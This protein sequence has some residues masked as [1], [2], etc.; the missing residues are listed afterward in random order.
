M[1]KKFGVVEVGGVRI[2]NTTREDLSMSRIP[3]SSPVNTPRLVPV[4]ALLAAILFSLGGIEPAGGR[5]RIIQMSPP[6][7]TAREEIALEGDWEYAFAPEISERPAAELQWKTTPVPMFHLRPKGVTVMWYRRRLDIPASWKNRRVHLVME[8]NATWSTVYLNGTKV[9]DDFTANAPMEADLTGAIRWEGANDLLLAVQSHEGHEWMDGVPLHGQ[10]GDKVSRYPCHYWTPLIGIGAPISLRAVAPVF[11]DSVAI[12]P[13]WRQKRLEAVA[14]VTNTMPRAL[15]VAIAAEVEEGVTLPAVTVTVPAHGCAQAVLA[16]AWPNPRL[17]QI[18]EPNLY[19]LRTTLTQDGQVV[20]DRRDRFGFRE[21]W[22]EGTDYYFNG[23]KFFLKMCTTGYYPEGRSGRKP[24]ELKEEM[25]AMVRTALADN[26]N[27]MRWW[28]QVPGYLRDVCDEEGIVINDFIFGDGGQGKTLDDAGT[29]WIHSRQVFD[30][31]FKFHGNHPSV[32]FWTIQNEAWLYPAP[33]RWGEVLLAQMQETIRHIAAKDPT[34]FPNSDGDGDV[35]GWADYLR[36]SQDDAVEARE[37]GPA[38]QHSWHFGPGD[39]NNPRSYYWVEENKAPRWDKKKPLVLGEFDQNVATIFDHLHFY[40]DDAFT[41]RR[42]EHDPWDWYGNIIRAARV[43]GVAG[44][45]A[46][47]VRSDIHPVAVKAYSPELA[48]NRE[49]DMQ[50]YGGQTVPRRFVAINGTFYSN[51]APFRW[52]LKT[53][54]GRVLDAG[55]VPL[56]IAPGDRQEFGIEVQLPEVPARVDATLHFV[57]GAYQDHVPFRIWPALQPLTDMPRKVWV[58]DPE[59]LS[60]EAVR[61]AV[62]DAVAV[63]DLTA[64]DKTVDLLVMGDASV[65]EVLPSPAVEAIRRYAEGGGRVLVLQQEETAPAGLFPVALEIE[66]MRELKAKAF[67]LAR[68]HELL[69][70]L[71]HQ[72]FRF[73]PNDYYVARFPY[74]K[75]IRGLYRILLQTSHPRGLTTTPLLEMPAG[76]GLFLCSQLDLCAKAGRAPVADL[77]LRRLIAYALAFK[78]PASKRAALVT[79][80]DSPTA[81]K[82]IQ[83]CGVVAEVMPKLTTADLS[84]LDVVIVDGSDEAIAERW[85]ADRHA[86]RSWL[87]EG[88]TLLWHRA[89]PEHAPLL[90]PLVYVRLAKL[91]QPPHSVI[92]RRPE[93]PLL[94]GIAE[95]DLYYGTFARFPMR[96]QTVPVIEFAAHSELGQELLSNG[97]LVRLPL[98]KGQVLISQVLWDAY[99]L[100]QKDQEVQDRQERYIVMLL[101]NLG[102]P[103]QGRPLQIQAYNI[104]EEQAFFVNLRPFVNMAFK[105]ETSGDRKG[106]WT[107]QGRND[108]RYFPTGKRRFQGVPFDVIVAD[109]N[110]NRACL[111]IRLAQEVKPDL[112]QRLVQEGIPVG[113]KANRLFFLHACAWTPY[114][115]RPV[116]IY[117]LVYED[118]SEHEFTMNSTEHFRDWWVPAKP[119]SPEA[120]VAWVGRLAYEIGVPQVAMFL[121]A[122]ANPH[123]EKTVTAIKMRRAFEGRTSYVLAGITAERVQEQ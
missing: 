92:K 51:T 121:T 21:F 9:A 55:T 96:S 30:R 78:A 60:Q 7:L 104:P 99:T 81:T 6:A 68:G 31:F 88:N 72:D 45:H 119:T 2:Y 5:E 65:T 14:E 77:M 43:Q 67:H 29:Y 76:A 114:D 27:T 18:G 36:L 24:A 11:I 58:Y 46:W 42:E 23:A 89:R 64:L 32:F 94:T 110:E 10:G 3:H 73:W 111:N 102:V 84:G 109:E 93:D 74:A 54:D 118:G 50:F 53:R 38:P 28:F 37:P 1:G 40:G 13:S 120:H 116:T 49:F 90:N 113:I 34:R 12:R 91:S 79:A 47:A 63:E 98:G 19:W 25:R 108:M 17:W 75:P 97:A 87:A 57:Y 123:P 52:Q 70:G 15:S 95:F 112:Y 100:E 85:V 69:D 101:S 4:R 56:E 39:G 35:A 106:G 59:G 86:L 117:T 20:D 122:V 48:V 83:E 80:K 82:L 103:N 61:R 71:D 41:G 26:L 66:G 115:I 105:D 107:D 33:G 16:Q 8:G 22:I 62:P 44:T